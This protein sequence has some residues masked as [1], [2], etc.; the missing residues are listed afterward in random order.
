MGL[1]TSRSESDWALLLAMTIRFLTTEFTYICSR[2]L[3]LIIMMNL[4]RYV[5]LNFS[6]FYSP[7]RYF[8]MR[9]Y[10]FVIDIQHFLSMIWSLLKVTNFFFINRKIVTDKWQQNYW[11]SA[12][13]AM[14]VR[15]DAKNMK[16][17]IFRFLIYFRSLD[18]YQPFNILWDIIV[19]LIPL[20]YHDAGNIERK[21]SS[22]WKPSVA[23]GSSSYQVQFDINLSIA[24]W[25]V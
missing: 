1:V 19:F 6:N 11:G 12:F 23:G 20:T 17:F 14:A 18:P 15:S 9:F 8:W 3:W 25:T 7:L 21:K 16:Y 13:F 24:L 2:W 22:H 5:N 4:W 10:F